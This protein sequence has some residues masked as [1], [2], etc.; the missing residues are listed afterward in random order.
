V[1]LQVIYPL[2][3][4]R[5]PLGVYKNIIFWSTFAVVRSFLVLIGKK[6]EKKKKRKEK[7]PLK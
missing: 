7:K 2:K 4:R 3:T 6:K 1:T 5:E